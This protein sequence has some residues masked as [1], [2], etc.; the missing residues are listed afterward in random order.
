MAAIDVQ[1]YVMNTATVKI[2]SDTY[3]D[4]LSSVVLTPTTPKSNFLAISGKNRRTAGT[5]EW[6]CAITFAQDVKSASSFH[7]YLHDT[8]PGTIVTMEFTPLTGGDKVTADIMIEPAAI[9][10]DAGTTPTA[11]VT[12]DVEGQPTRTAPS[13]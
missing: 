3:E 10:G 9:G 6:T 7:K 5:P 4:A 13:S 8:A 1:P 2:G 11:S 12:L